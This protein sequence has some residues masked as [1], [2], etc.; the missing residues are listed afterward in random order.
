V[1][2]IPLNGAGGPFNAAVRVRSTTEGDAQDGVSVAR[3]ASLL[4]DPLIYRMATP[5]SPRP[6][7][8]VEFR[9]TERIQVR[10]PVTGAIDGRQGR[11]LGRDGVPLALSPTLSDREEGATRFVVADLNLAP[12]TAGEYIIE[13]TATGGGKTDAAHLAIRVGR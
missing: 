11:I 7:G 4:G 10:W 9:R 5:T 13:V 1:V 8:S 12:L 2:R 3:P 6:A